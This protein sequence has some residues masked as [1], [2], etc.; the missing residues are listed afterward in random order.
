MTKKDLTVMCLC[1]KLTRGQL[2]KLVF[3]TLRLA[4]VIWKKKKKNLN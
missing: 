2:F 4:R 1:V 3:V